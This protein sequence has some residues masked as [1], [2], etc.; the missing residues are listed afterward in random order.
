M[1]GDARKK[2]GKFSSNWEGP[3]RI[4]DT[5]AGGAY[6]LEHLSGK[7]IPRMWNATHLKFYYT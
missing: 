7:N 1:R 6:Y 4:A 3:F 2:G 5:A